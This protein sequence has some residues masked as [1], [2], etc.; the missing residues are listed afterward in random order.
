MGKKKRQVSAEKPIGQN[1][2]LTLNEMG[3]LKFERLRVKLRMAVAAVREKKM[4]EMALAL[5]QAV[6]IM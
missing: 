1:R 5:G 4:V 3:I 2:S 6:E